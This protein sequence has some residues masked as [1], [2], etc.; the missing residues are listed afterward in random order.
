M[1]IDEESIFPAGVEEDAVGG[2]VHLEVDHLY[3]AG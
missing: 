1:P 3:F 2:D